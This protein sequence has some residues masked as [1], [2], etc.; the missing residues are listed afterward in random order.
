M[1]SSKASTFPLNPTPAVSDL[2]VSLSL[3]VSP[4]PPSPLFPSLVVSPSLPPSSQTIFRRPLTPSRSLPLCR[5]PP[6]HSF[7][8]TPLPPRPSFV[9]VN[10]RLVSSAAI[11]A[12]VEEHVCELQLGLASFAALKASLRTHCLMLK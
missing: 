6:I 1:R 11:L 10:L 2:S 3:C 12:R 5:S 4:T 9:A 7:V 8:P